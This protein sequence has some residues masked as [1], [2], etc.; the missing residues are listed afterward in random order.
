MRK[1]Q[2]FIILTLIVFLI[3]LSVAAG[4]MELSPKIMDKETQDK[5]SHY[6]HKQRN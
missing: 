2:H 4:K 3:A 6:G 1:P 5:Y